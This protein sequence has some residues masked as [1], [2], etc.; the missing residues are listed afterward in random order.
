MFDV[1]SKA[2]KR[3]RNVSAYLEALNKRLAYIPAKR[4]SKWEDEDIQMILK[5]EEC[6]KYQLV[7]N[8]KTKNIEPL[9][10]SLKYYQIWL[11]LYR[12]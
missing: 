9:G 2:I 3:N 6:F 5:A 8:T 11:I 4:F 12:F 10:G 1:I 7:F